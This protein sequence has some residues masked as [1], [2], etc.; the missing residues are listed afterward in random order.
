VQKD[1]EL[2]EDLQRCEAFHAYA[3]KH[4]Y[5]L[6]FA[7]EPKER[8]AFIQR[9]ALV[10]YPTYFQEGA[11]CFVDMHAYN[12]DNRWYDRLGLPDMPTKTYFARATLKRPRLL[13]AAPR[14]NGI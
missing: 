10:P 4:P 9:A 2:D 5:L 11:T 8:A 1:K 13:L 7:Q 14:P 6:R 3:E 12:I